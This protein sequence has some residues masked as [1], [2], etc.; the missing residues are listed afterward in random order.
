MHGELTGSPPTILISGTRDLFLSN[1]V[2]VH[3][4]LRRAG[5]TSDLH[6][7]EGRSHAQYLHASTSRETREIFGEIAA[8]SR[9]HLASDRASDLDRE[10]RAA[11]PTAT[12]I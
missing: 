7:F 11:D 10:S 2:R 9:T 1:T 8:F 6:V 4:A 3:R 5:A 12:P